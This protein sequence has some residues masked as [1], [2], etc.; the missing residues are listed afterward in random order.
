MLSLV[1]S[2][3]N[4]MQDFG[5]TENLEDDEIGEW[6]IAVQTDDIIETVREFI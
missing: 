4:G 5:T 6:Q 1:Y 2:L 3:F